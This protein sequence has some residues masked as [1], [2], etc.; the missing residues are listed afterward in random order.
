MKFMEWNIPFFDYPQQF[1]GNE[2]KYM[3][4][5]RKTLQEGAYILGDDLK[6][7]EKNLAR[8][9]GTEYAVGVNNCTDAL[10]ISLYAAGIGAGDEVISVSHTFVAT[11]EVIKFL[12]AIPVLVDIADDH[13]MDVDLIEPL[14]TE[15][16]KA[17][18]PVH[19]NGSICSNIEKLQ[20]IAEK[21]NLVII[22]DAAQSLGALYKKKGAGSFGLAGCFSF[23]P[24]KLLGTFGDAG[25]IVTDDFNFYKYVKMIRNHG[26]GD[27]GYINCWGIN[28]RMDN[29]HAAI[30]DYKLTLLKTSITRR[31]EIA[32]MYFEGLSDTNELLLPFPPDGDDDRYNVY[33]NY[34]I[35]AEERDELV[36]YLSEKGIQTMLPWGGNGVHQFYTLNMGNYNL[37]K[38]EEL[39]KKVVMLPLYPELQNNQIN[40]IITSI[41]DYYSN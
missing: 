38:T 26:R 10:L 12:G 2:L 21:Y 23:Y 41:R 31:R 28:S 40:Y 1:M 27:D 7:F 3:E 5:I 4:I 17:I 15:K 30:L 35:E 25:A 37:I 6:Q 33:Q 18:I 32:G 34:E 29:I 22:E 19:L 36:Y 16:T 9:V 8:F 24:A 13:N 14:I 11:I 20:F 39:F